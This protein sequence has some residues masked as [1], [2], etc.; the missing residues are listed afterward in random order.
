[1]PTLI[2]EFL[3]FQK[4]E[5]LLEKTQIQHLHDAVTYKAKAVESYFKALENNIKK[6]QKF[7]VI[8]RNLSILECFAREPNNYAA[9]QQS[10]HDQLE[11]INLLLPDIADIML[12]DK[13]DKVVF[14]LRVV[15]H[16][17]GV[18]KINDVQ[19]KAITE[20]KKHIYFSDIYYD[21]IHDNRCE[22]LITAPVMDV[23]N[24][25]SGIVVFELRIEPL[26][27]MIQ[28]TIALGETGESYVVKREGDEIVYL[29]PLKF[30]KN[31]G[32]PKRIKF[33]SDRAVA[34][35][36]ALQGQTGAEVNIDYRGKKV[37][38]AWTYLRPLN[39]GLVAKIDTSEAFESVSDLKKLVAGML[40]I[41][42]LFMGLTAFYISALVSRPIKELA[43]GALIIGSGN[44]DYKIRMRRKDEIGKLAVS[45]EKMTNDLKN[46]M[47][48]R[49]MLNREIEERKKTEESLRRSEAKYRELV[50]Y[51]NS[52]I[53][54]WDRDGRITFFN[55]YAEK[56]FGYKP[57][58]VMG[59]NINII[60]PPKESTGRDLTGLIQDIVR[61][62]EKYLYNVNENIRKDG[63]RVWMAWTNRPIYDENGQIKE[64]MS[65]ATDITES[66]K[67]EEE[68]AKVNRILRALSDSNQVMMHAKDEST[69]IREICRIVEKDCGYKMVL[70]SYVLNDE[71]KTVKPAIY[72]GFEKDY[73]SRLKIS[74]AD[75]EYGRGPTGTAART[76]QVQIC[77]DMATDPNFAPWREEALQRGYRSSIALPLKQNDK[78]FGTITVISNLPDAFSKDEVELLTEL[79]NDFAYGLVSLRTRIQREKDQEE[80][81]RLSIELQRSNQELEEFA[82][83]VSHDL[84][85]PLRAVSGFL[86]LLQQRYKDKLD[87]KANEY[88]DFAVN[89]SRIMRNML[90]GLLEYSRVQTAGHEF[91]EVCANES[92]EAAIN[93]LS[94]RIKETKAEITHDKLPKIKGDAAQLTQ[95]F[96]NLIQNAIKFRSQ[97]NPR[98]HISA[99]REENGWL[100]SVADNGIGIEPQY[101]ESIFGVFQRLHPSDEFD[102]M[103]M[104]LAVCKRIVKRHKGYIWADS[105]PGKGSTFY[106]IIPD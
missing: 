62:P 7:P 80:L 48:S 4:Y 103:G 3:T 12:I 8:R 33:V 77:R 79:A 37:I 53:I 5:K 41:L 49:D 86:E 72:E 46:T 23:N 71:A 105:E 58:E 100:F 31:A 36:K 59:Q 13:K 106:F 32:L 6:I 78:V 98:I 51:A 82:D 66:K 40:F 21:D 97:A 1:M 18:P 22:M 35:Q 47:A 93:N 57:Q 68:L 29:S 45:F 56:F 102:G 42:L 63:R 27:S 26:Y 55:E 73:V 88:I 92:L 90:L 69:Y 10:L 85:E 70:F 67:K 99:E 28:E 60:V 87:S 65:V 9:I 74:W 20:G 91:S 50:Q 43:A 64:I 25:F 94:V 83:I 76:G 11:Q 84:R 81:K 96:Q 101:L 14:S 16:T 38:S 61:N 44:L 39:W 17:F 19:Q 95:L 34:T 89:G 104:G 75:N 24:V 2:V 52:A 54:R 30:T 15:H